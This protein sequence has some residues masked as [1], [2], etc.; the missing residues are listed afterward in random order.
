ML[1]KRSFV[2][3]KVVSLQGEDLGQVPNEGRH[4]PD[5]APKVGKAGSGPVHVIP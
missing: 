2:S 4:N 3:S 1:F 5:L